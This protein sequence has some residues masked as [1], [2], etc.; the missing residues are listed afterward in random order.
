MEI[1]EYSSLDSNKRKEI[2]KKIKKTLS[3]R[4][5]VVFACVFGSFI[6]SLSFRDIDIGIYLEKIDERKSLDYELKLSKKIADA[7]GLPSDVI[8]V[9]ILNFVPDYFLNNV[10][11]HGVLL[12]SRNQIL[13]TS[14]IER[15]SLNALANECISD[16]SLRELISV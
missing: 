7:C 2:T 6:D 9:H 4:K 8:E 10:F 5:D 15:T 11:C 16:Q 14:L 3:G 13:T 1:K 12:F